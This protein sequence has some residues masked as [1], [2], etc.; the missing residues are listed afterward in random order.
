MMTK[1][2]TTL[3]WRGNELFAGGVFIGSVMKDPLHP[4]PFLA[5]LQ[6]DEVGAGVGR[7]PTESAA[8]DALMNAAVKAL[9]G[10]S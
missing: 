4:A 7:Y 6:S 10:Q 5:W 1:V 2:E 9:G 8:R 3:T